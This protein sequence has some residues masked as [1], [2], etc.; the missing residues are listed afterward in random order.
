M[1]GKKATLLPTL[2]YLY[3]IPQWIKG[4]GE[5]VDSGVES[6]LGV[7]AACSFL[8]LISRPLANIFLPSPAILF[9][10]RSVQINCLGNFS[11]SPWLL[12]DLCKVDF[13]IELLL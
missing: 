11:S 13:S 1:L 9:L 12:T 5:Q 10:S 4:W 2:P 7:K 3:I 8:H 6:T